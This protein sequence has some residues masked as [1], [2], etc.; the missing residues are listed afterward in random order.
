VKINV[1]VQVEEDEQAIDREA[2]ALAIL[3][4]LN[5]DPSKDEITLYVQTAPPDPVRLGP[6]LTPS[7][8]EL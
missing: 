6:E 5:G 3:K 8:P 2:A 1:N 7:P 4:A